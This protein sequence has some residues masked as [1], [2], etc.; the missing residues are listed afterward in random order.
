MKTKPQYRKAVMVGLLIASGALLLVGC[1]TTMTAQKQSEEAPDFSRA[2]MLKADIA[3]K[4]AVSCFDREI[5]LDRCKFRIDMRR[6]QAGWR[7]TFIYLPEAPDYS[8]VVL[9]YDDGRTES[10]LK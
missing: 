10:F 7:V 6:V 9:V 8:G 5:G 1:R 3:L 4:E 2:T